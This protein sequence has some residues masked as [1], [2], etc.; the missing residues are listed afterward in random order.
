MTYHAFPPGF[1][2]GKMFTMLARLSDCVTAEVSKS[3][4]AFCYQ[5]LMFGQQNNPLGLVDA[6][7]GLGVS[8]T[9]PARSFSSSSFPNEDDPTATQRATC[10]G[11]LALE[12]EIGVA[13]CM[14]RPAGR[15]AQ[16]D[17]QSVFEASRLFMADMYAM[18]RAVLCCF[19][20]QYPDAKVALGA[21]SPID[22][23]GGVAGSTWTAWLG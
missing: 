6:T 17:P 13:R 4:G 16:P 22:T 14:P 11:A 19:K 2:D 9:R 18:R 23:A 7:K 12:M 21:W 5:G 15:N 3:G 1:T 8:W 20:E 10:K